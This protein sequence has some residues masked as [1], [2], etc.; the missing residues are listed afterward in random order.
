MTIIISYGSYGFG[1]VFTV[2][3][4]GQRVSHSFTEINSIV[5]QLDWYLFPNEIQKIMP[6]IINNVQQPIEIE[7]FGDVRCNRK[8]FKKVSSKQIK[9]YSKP[10]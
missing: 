5:D 7:C 1:L 10:I 2:C 6:I 9:R 8:S 4:L 3:E